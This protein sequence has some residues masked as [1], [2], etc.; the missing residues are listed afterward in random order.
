MPNI[1]FLNS[2]PLKKD[3]LPEINNTD[4]VLF[5]FGVIG[6]RRGIFT[7]LDAIPEIKRAIPSIKLVL[8]GRVD[9]ADKS[10]FNNHINDQNKKDNIIFTGWQ[11]ISLLPSF[12][13]KTDVC[14]CPIIGS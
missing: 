5:Y 6:K 2:F 13:S 7:C 4:F 9:K 3:V 8:T 14:L 12:L 10:E 1:N 11:D